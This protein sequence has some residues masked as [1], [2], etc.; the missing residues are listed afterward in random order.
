[1]YSPPRSSFEAQSQGLHSYE[2]GT[3][4]FITFSQRTE[5]NGDEFHATET[6]HGAE[7]T[8][9]DRGRGGKLGLTGDVVRWSGSLVVV[10]L[11]PEFLTT[12]TDPSCL[13]S[14][15]CHT[16]TGPKKCGGRMSVGDIITTRPP[17]A[18]HV[19]VLTMTSNSTGDSL[20]IFRY[21]LKPGIY[22]IQNLF[23]QTYMDIHEHTKEVCC[24]PA[25]NLGEGKGLVG[26]LS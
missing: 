17:R 16:P 24:R 21:E 11:G 6:I 14:S 4:Q 18:A 12:V 26:L 22:K 7:Y 19:L 1:M 23:S 2:G 25:A 9:L 15:L 13:W 5:S 3:R 8:A 10:R 20:S